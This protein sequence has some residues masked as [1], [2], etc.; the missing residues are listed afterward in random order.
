MLGVQ[1]HLPIVV[2]ACERGLVAVGQETAK[3]KGWEKRCGGFWR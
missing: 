3:K 1:G 2:E